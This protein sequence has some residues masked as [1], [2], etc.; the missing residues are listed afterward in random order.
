[1]NNTNWRLTDWGVRA[2]YNWEDKDDKEKTEQFRNNIDIEM[3]G[4]GNYMLKLK[5]QK[6]HSTDDNGNGIR[7][8]SS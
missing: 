6:T 3:N 4:Y 1:M 7:T 2:N 5:S 8:G